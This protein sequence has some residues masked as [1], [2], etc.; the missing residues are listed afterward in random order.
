MAEKAPD[1]EPQPAQDLRVMSRADYA[2]QIREHLMAQPNTYLVLDGDVVIGEFDSEAE[3]VA[4][5]AEAG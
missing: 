1:A 4:Y 5:V 3:A 2:V